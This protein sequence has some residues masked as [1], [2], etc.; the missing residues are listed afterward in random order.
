M[1]VKLPGPV[2]T[3]SAS[4]SSGPSMGVSEQRIDVLEQRASDRDPFAEHAA[5]VD[6]RAGRDVRCRVEGEEEHQSMPSSSAVSAAAISSCSPIASRVLEA[7]RDAGGGKADEPRLGPLDEDDGVL[8]VGLEVAPLRRREPA[9]A[10]EIEVRD[11]H[12]AV[13]R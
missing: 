6:E 11:V 10:E 5:V 3:T 8:E 7:H 13:P 12:G 9:E 4:R 2:P 1:L